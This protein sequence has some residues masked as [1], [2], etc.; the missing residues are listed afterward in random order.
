MK[1][2]PTT[3]I[4][5]TTTAIEHVANFYDKGDAIATPI[6]TE[7]TERI[8]ALVAQATGL[9]VASSQD[10]EALALVHQARMAL[11][12]TRTS[13]ENRRKGLVADAL[14]HQRKVNA[15][16]KYLT[17]LI[18]P[19][20]NRLLFVEGIVEREAAEARKELLRKEEERIAR[21]RQE[22]LDRQAEAQRQHNERIL[23]ERK[24]EIEK[25]NKEAADR[26]ARQEAELK[27]RSER[28]AREE[29]EA[30][31]QRRQM[32]EQRRRLQEREERQVREQEELEEQRRELR[33]EEERRQQRQEAE[34]DERRRQEYAKEPA[35][36]DLH[37]ENEL[38]QLEKEL[39]QPLADI[40]IELSASS[41]Q[42]RMSHK[43]DGPAAMTTQNMI[44][45]DRNLLEHRLKLVTESM[46]DFEGCHSP[47][48]HAIWTEFAVAI[49]ATCRATL[50]RVNAL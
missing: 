33:K 26:I 11:K 16:A 24:A 43:Y 46:E 31:E 49:H 29:E 17:A 30:A 35:S 25:A 6:Q 4:E 32:D 27:A 14:K 18:E 47:M 19:E 28:Q 20:E 5:I 9:K 10:T 21:E 38:T 41:D 42:Q 13:I 39:V 48:A 40:G 45:E 12:N 44:E 8:G 50:A 7:L 36:M 1:E 37:E 3:E 23:A 22:E 34:E 2:Q 15:A